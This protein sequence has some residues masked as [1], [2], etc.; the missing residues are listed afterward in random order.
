MFRSV[1]ICSRY[2]NGL[3]VWLIS[4][5][6]RSLITC[7]TFIATWRRYT[8][9]ASRNSVLWSLWSFMTTR[10]SWRNCGQHSVASPTTSS[11]S[12]RHART[13]SR[14]MDWLRPSGY[15]NST[16][17]RCWIGYWFINVMKTTRLNASELLSKSND[18]LIERLTKENKYLRRKD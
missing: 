10:S 2:R 7:G 8:Q 3:R 15:T 11:R 18:Q 16:R 13:R 6:L 12:N 9:D 1:R 4:C 5:S 17:R 14:R